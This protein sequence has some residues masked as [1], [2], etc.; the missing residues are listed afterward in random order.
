M[1]KFL[2]VIL[3]FFL[4]LTI[5]FAVSAQSSN[6]NIPDRD[7]DFPDPDHPGIRVRVFVHNPK[8]A[9]GSSDLTPAT[10]SPD[11]D[12]ATVDGVTGWKLPSTNWNY[13]VNSASAPSGVGGNAVTITNNAFAA[14]TGALS[15]ASSKPTFSYAGP[16]SVNKNVYDGQ[17][18]VAWGH[19]SGSAL[20]VTYTRY[21]QS[22]GVVVDVDTIF[23]SKFAWT[24]N[25]CS[26]SAYDAQ[27]I[28]THELGHWMGLD[29][30]Y[31]ASFADN[32]MYG[33][34]AKAENKK[35]TPAT[36]DKN[37]LLTIYH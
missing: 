7:G 26:A 25:T 5:V 32:T 11:N 15:P 24:W 13:R 35:D 30:N 21:N 16:T 17:N 10:C 8:D 34:G 23:N 9:R 6:A 22:T 18:I 12:S 37:A 19:T 14:W 33:Y 4:V 20:A 29:D 36:G 1:K 27:D 2:G 31:A 28:L 3:G